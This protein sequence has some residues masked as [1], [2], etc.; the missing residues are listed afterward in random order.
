[1]KKSL[2]T[3]LLNISVLL[4]LFGCGPD[5]NTDF[6]PPPAEGKLEDIFPAEIGNMT[7][8]L[9]RV[10]LNP[11]L[12]GFT[13]VYGSNY[14]VIN[15]IL[16]PDK[17]AAD[18]YFEHAI[19]PNIDEMKNHTRGKYNGKWRASGTDD[20]GRVWFGWV[21]NRWVFVLNG[22]DNRYF[23]MG[24]DAFAYVEE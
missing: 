11:P 7:V 19:V 9:S 21:N 3:F 1:M 10:N 5:F 8:K 18:D 6:D 14:I 24:I 23:K 15:A 12:V 13:G 2:V 22:L 16:L 17:A 4:L 20:S